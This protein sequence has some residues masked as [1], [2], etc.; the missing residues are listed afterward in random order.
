MIATIAVFFALFGFAVGSFLN[1]CIDRLPNG[2]SL[3][4]PASHCD[5]CGRR[6]A[7][8]DLVPVLSYLWLRGRCR[9]CDA[10]VPVRVLLVELAA[11]LLF[12]LLYWH[13]DLHLH[14]VFALIYT[15]IF[16][17]VFAID[18][19]HQLIL[20]KVVA[21]SL[22]LALIFSSFWPELGLKDELWPAPGI[23]SALVG[24]A[25]GFAILLVVYL[26]FRGG[27]G[28]GDVKLAALLGVITGF[29]FIIMALLLSVVGGGIVASFL[30][31]S[32]LKKRGEA[33][34][35][36]PFLVSG[37]LITFLWG[38]YLW[39]WYVNFPQRYSWA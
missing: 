4:R 11:G 38:Q 16:I 31:V 19:E 6:L 2:K 24:G 17:V 20:D 25:T 32:R 13:Y 14:L 23:K 21:P 30:L 7:P 5:S 22:I 35:F 1:L 36:G 37:T 9:Y 10:R 12:A 8:H 26:I 18:L 34:P 15:S 3:V 33:I 27:F 28:E 39:D 29:P